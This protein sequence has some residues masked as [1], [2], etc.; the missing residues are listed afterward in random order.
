MEPNNEITPQTGETIASEGARKTSTI[1]TLENMREQCTIMLSHAADQ[2]TPIPDAVI[3]DL[4]IADTK[5]DAAALN[6]AH[7]AL[8]RLVEPATPGA[9]MYLS[10]ESEEAVRFWRFLGPVTTIRFM[11]VASICSLGF[12]LTFAAT[13]KVTPENLDTTLLHRE[14]SDAIYV[15]LFLIAASAIGVSFN[16]LFKARQFVIEGTYDPKYNTTYWMRFVLGLTS[17]YILAEVITLDFDATFQKPLL[18]LVGGF[19]ADTVYNILERIVEGV[20]AIVRGGLSERLASMKAEHKAELDHQIVTQN[21]DIAK[22]T[23]AMRD[24]MK[25]AGATDDQIAKVDVIIRDLIN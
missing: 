24:E 8:A 7:T 25:K 12:F 18:A 17:G 6:H 21:F 15:S 1:E 16:N 20:R 4:H 22:K 14:G 23:M 11:A 3:Q 10:K 13:G 5:A 19:A 2:G 9:L